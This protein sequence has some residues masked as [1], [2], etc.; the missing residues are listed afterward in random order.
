MEGNQ[1]SEQNQI[2]LV[3]K[4]EGVLLITIN[5]PEKRN[6][7]AREVLSLIKDT[8]NSFRDDQSIKLAVLTGAGD[9][10]FAAGG[11]L[12]DLYDVR[13]EQQTREMSDEAFQCLEAVRQF[14]LPVIAVLN[15]NALG[16]G[17]ELAIACDFRLAAAHARI[18]FIQGKLNIT[19]AWGGGP[20]LVNLVGARQALRLF[21]TSKIVKPTEALT[22]GLFDQVAE[23][24]QSNEQL[25]DDF[26]AP[27]ISKTSTV[28][29]G[30]KA[31][32]TAKREGLNREQLRD[33]E[34]AWLV[35]SWTEQPHWDAV[36][37]FMNSRKVK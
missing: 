6:A 24:G 16:G 27:M 21:A 28:L 22:L 19:S 29:R 5:R 11:D 20:D 15:G 7:L 31:L 35:K 33:V 18:G 34:A 25:I 4:K 2:V 30:F 9:K 17:S 13:T 26:I 36:D 37:Q 32:S 14:P 3:E 12:H 23:Q 8:F 1:L 10:S